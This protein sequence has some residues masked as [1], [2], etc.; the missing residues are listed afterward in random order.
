MFSS[1]GRRRG[2]LVSRRLEQPE[3]DNGPSRAPQPGAIF[4]CKAR[5]AAGRDC[6]CQAGCGGA[7]LRALSRYVEVTESAVIY[8]RES[9][10]PPP[11]GQSPARR[12]EEPGGNAALGCGRNSVSGTEEWE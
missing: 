3:S 9:A 10:G 1:E 2:G 8:R 5:P 11:N 6:R 7:E 12:R 4:R